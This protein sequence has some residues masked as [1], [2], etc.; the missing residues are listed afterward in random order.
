MSRARANGLQVWCLRPHKHNPKD[1]QSLRDW[2]FRFLMLKLHSTSIKTLLKRN[3]ENE[4]FPTKIV[5][6]T[7]ICRAFTIYQTLMTL[8]HLLCNSTQCY[9]Y[10][11][12]NETLLLCTYTLTQVHKWLSKPQENF[13]S[14]FGDNIILST[15]LWIYNFGLFHPIGHFSFFAW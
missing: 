4:L 7:N 9:R 1:L 13:L 15:F 5:T 2:T 3:T 10:F 6:M 14:S 8:L 11:S 12:F